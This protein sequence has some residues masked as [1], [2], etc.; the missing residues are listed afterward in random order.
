MNIQLSGGHYDGGKFW[1]FITEVRENGTYPTGYKMDN[2]ASSNMAQ[3][4]TAQLIDE[5]ERTS[6]SHVA[7]RYPRHIVKFH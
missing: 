3:R 2:T 1:Q 5:M 6:V 4:H 7:A